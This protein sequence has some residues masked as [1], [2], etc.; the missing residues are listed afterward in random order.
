MKMLFRLLIT[1]CLAAAGSTAQAQI[2]SASATSLN[3][4]IYNPQSSSNVDNTATISVSCQATLSLL[5]IYSVKLSSGSSGS[6][7]QRK[8]LSGANTLNYQV[9]DDSARSTIWGDGTSSTN[10]IT[11]G[12]L[13]Q[14]L[15]PV[16]KTYTAY[17]RT[18]GSQNAKA[19]AYTDTLTIL[20]TY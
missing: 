15:G 7:A 2:C 16:V 17:G 19:G 4:G 10:F 1:L 14:V 9:Y 20:V 3:F 8:M 11:D 6:F 18:P 13:L 12:Y 5:M